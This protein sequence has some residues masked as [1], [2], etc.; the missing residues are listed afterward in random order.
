MRFELIQLY[1]IHRGL[2]FKRLVVAFDVL[3][4]KVNHAPDRIEN[5][6][7]E[8]VHQQANKNIFDKKLVEKMN[9]R[10]FKQD[11]RHAKQQN[12]RQRTGNE[13]QN[14]K[15]DPSQFFDEEPEQVCGCNKKHAE[16]NKAQ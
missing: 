1:L 15:P 4:E 6:R 12:G 13:F 2:I 3:V 8:Q 11:I 10:Y 9:E 7:S 14:I 16:K 5:H